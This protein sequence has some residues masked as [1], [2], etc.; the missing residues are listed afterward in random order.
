M[1]R[2]RRDRTPRRWCI[3]PAM[4][5]GPGE[6]IEGGDLLEE[7]QDELG[8]LLWRT[9][10]DVALW[11]ETPPEDRGR[12]FV[13]GGDA[14]RL[15]APGDPAL[16]R[17][18][19]Q[20]LETIHAVLAD[21][22]RAD[23]AELSACC[24]QVAAWARDEGLVHTAIAF[25]QAGALASPQL[26]EAA[27]QTGTAAAAAGQDVRAE[28]WLRRAVGLAR[29]EKDRP[30][31][32]TALVELGQLY[33]R[34]GNF[35]RAE[36]L[37]QHG[38]RAARR[39]RVRTARMRAAHGLLRL[40]RQLGDATRA[41]QFALAAQQVCR[42]NMDG[43]PALLLELARFW[44]DAGE[45]DQARVALKRL[46]PARSRLAKA[47]QLTSAALTARAFAGSGEPIARAAADHARRLVADESIPDAVRF[48]A[49][50][51]LAHAAR[52]SGDLV[53]FTR[54]KGAVLRL[55]PAES[56]AAVAGEV[57]Q[58]WPDGR[59][60]APRLDRAS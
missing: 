59:H 57:A 58:L 22:G 55:A 48:A 44:T 42:T 15:A 32:A 2:S 21:S 11:G 37:Y 30:S 54:A 14:L 27:L 17:P 18:I 52:A 53:A 3:P 28:S 19:V 51:D 40:A 38:H 46:A 1:K 39:G 7:V 41:V 50:L 9:V 16:P 25:A 56:F 47:D 45:A 31:Y 6:T 26:A 8:V 43:G 24:L 23:A 5:R 13:K 33:E 29:R 49:A 35:A 36:N 60:D 20:P 34:R 10:R 4:L 12:L